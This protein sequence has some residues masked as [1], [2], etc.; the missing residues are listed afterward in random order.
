MS[1]DS[2][3]KSASDLTEVEVNPG[4]EMLRVPAISEGDDLRYDEGDP[5]TLADVLQRAVDRSPDKGIVYIQSDGTTVRQS[6]PSY[7]R[8]LN[9]FC[10][11]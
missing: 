3:P 9:E 8:M 6:Y 11:G 7:W 10:V 5:A 4:K 2:S 1:A